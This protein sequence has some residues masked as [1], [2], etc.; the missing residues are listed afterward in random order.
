MAAGK[1]DLARLAVERGR[2][3][4]LKPYNKYNGFLGDGPEP[5]ADNAQRK[6]E[7]RNG[8]SEPR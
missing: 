2:G 4:I 5:I 6:K 8:K 3:R 1:K 7:K